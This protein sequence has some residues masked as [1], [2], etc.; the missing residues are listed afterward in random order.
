LTD[1]ESVSY[2]DCE[3]PP[4]EGG[5]APPLQIQNSTTCARNPVALDVSPRRFFRERGGAIVG[6][7]TA[8]AGSFDVGV[9]GHTV[10]VFADTRRR[11]RAVVGQ[12]RRRSQAAP[13]PRLAPPAYPYRV[14]QELKRVLVARKRSPTARGIARRTGVPVRAVRTRL[15]LGRLVGARALR[16]IPVPRRSW[17]AVERDRQVSISAGEESVGA[18]ARQFRLTHAQVRRAVRRVRGLTGSC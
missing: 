11:A 4:G 10:A 7:Y 1:D 12:L 18:A 9:G 17:S 14:R 15:A 5:C 8:N 2:G 13:P 6:D 3:L 16:G